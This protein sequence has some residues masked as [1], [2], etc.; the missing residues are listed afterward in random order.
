MAGGK[1][2][3]DD[4]GEQIGPENAQDTADGRSDQAG[5]TDAAQVPLEQNDGNTDQSADT[6][7][8]LCRQGKGLNEVAGDGNNKD[9]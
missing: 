6:S 4:Q 5:E 3:A 8:Q 9:K 2:V 1:A 7:V